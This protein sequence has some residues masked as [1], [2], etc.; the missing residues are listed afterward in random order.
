MFKLK[1]LLFK[2]SRYS[3]RLTYMNSMV[4]INQNPTIDTQKQERKEHK[5]NS[6]NIHQTTREEEEMNLN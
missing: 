1:S 2:T 6:K 4:T 3:Y 5:H